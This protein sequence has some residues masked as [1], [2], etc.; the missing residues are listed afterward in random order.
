MDRADP[1]LLA[2]SVQ[3]QTGRDTLPVWPGLLVCG[4]VFGGIQFYWSNYRTAA[5]VDIIGGMVTLLVLTLFFKVWQPTK[6]WRYPASRAEAQAHRVTLTG[7]GPARVVAVPAARGVRRTVGNAA[8]EEGARHDHLLESPVPGLHHAGHPRRRRWS[9]SRRA[10]P[11]LFDFAW[12]S[13]V[14]TATFFA[15]LIAG[16]L[17]GL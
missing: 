15:G 4:V 1:S 8:G 13:A 14:G 9:I 3:C 11:A 5:L 6:I 2:G 12:L 17:L 10:E 7:T 16:P